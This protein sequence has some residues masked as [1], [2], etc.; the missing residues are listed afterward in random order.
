MSVK[1]TEN[2]KTVNQRVPKVDALGLACGRAEFTDDIVIAGMLHGKILW[3]P[4]AHAEIK[5]IDTAEA[6]RVPGVKAVLC[7]K[8]VPRIRHTTA[9]QNYPE[10]S[11]YDSLVFDTKVRYVGDKVAAVAAETME[12]AELALLKIKVDYKVLPAVFDTAEAA[13][14]CAPVIHD[15]KD[16]KNIADAAHNIAAKFDLDIHENDWFSKADVII[17]NTY[18]TQYAQHCALEPHTAI[19][20]LDP[21][22]RLFIRTSTQV[23]FHVRRIVGQALN[24]PVKKI[25]VIKPRVGG[26]FGSKQEVFLEQVCAALTL[27]AKRPVRLELTRREV[28]ISSRTRHPSLTRLKSGVTK[29]GKITD[30]E[31]ELTLN[32]GAY[33]AH[34]LT[35][36]MS[37]GSH[38]LPTYQ[39]PNNKFI[40]RTVYTNLPVAGA[41]RGYGTTQACFPMECQMEMM[42]EAIGMDSIAFRLKNYIREGAGSPVFKAMGKGREGEKRV[43]TSCGI[44]ACIQKGLKEIDWYAK[45]EKYSGQTGVKRRGLGV[46]CSM[47]GSGVPEADMAAVTIK[48]NADGSFN[49]TAGTSDIGTGAETVLAQIAAEVLAVPADRIVVYSG[50]TDLAYASSNTLVAVNAA[51][52]CAMKMRDLLLDVAARV[53]AEKPID[54]RLENGFAV[55]ADG[56]KK[57]SFAEVARTSLFYNNRH[58]LCATASHT[59]HASPPPFAA[60][61]AEIEVDT[62]T[63]ELKV[64]DYVSTV[65]CG[66]ALN[67][68]LAEGQNDG[69]TL[70]GMSYALC[71]KMEFNAKG[72]VVNAGFGGY[73]VFT[74]HDAPPLRTFLIPT[75]EPNG[76]FGAKAVSEIGINCSVPAFANAIHNATGAWLFDPPFTPDKILAAIKAK[77]AGK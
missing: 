4:H 74:A 37:A 59:S 75:Y 5:S 2:F 42:A 54:L 63:G 55:T 20:W 12:A 57:C 58:Q 32:N 17:E 35:V 67:P 77:V 11:P 13:K 53:L 7:Y 29:T 39:A 16:A 56:K 46:A 34:A 36:M 1:E 28:F 41:Y 44:R 65:D 22:G 40:G 47:Q 50:D 14:P 76:P 38:S 27:A 24:V 15:E 66:T 64:I 19:T 62:E 70:N 18:R 60:H 33:G 71:E 25:R 9:G 49:L 45:L 10:P 61:F 52:K 48:A 8:N 31:M 51:R 68:V 30:L 69:A 6:E 72:A 73:R 43:M 21:N 23:P 26:G 3:S